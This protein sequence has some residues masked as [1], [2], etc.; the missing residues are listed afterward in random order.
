M[1]QPRSSTWFLQEVYWTTRL[2]SMNLMR[3]ICG[4]G[5]PVEHVTKR[6]KTLFSTKSHNNGLR[7]KCKFHIYQNDQG[8]L[9]RP[10]KI[11]ARKRKKFSMLVGLRRFHGFTGTRPIVEVRV[12]ERSILEISEINSQV[13]ATMN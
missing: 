12:F 11:T 10:E 13:L 7:K 4:A 6:E 5:H 2:P 3:A 1:S 9:K 8:P